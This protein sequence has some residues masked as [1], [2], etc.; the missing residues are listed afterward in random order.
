MFGILGIAFCPFLG[1]AAWVMGNNDLREMAA[2]RMD[3]TGR[4]MTK[5]GRV[6]GMIGTGLL[7]FQAIVMI[8]VMLSLAISRN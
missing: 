6:C 8:L 5:A 7:I 1:V 4:D 3:S 2:G